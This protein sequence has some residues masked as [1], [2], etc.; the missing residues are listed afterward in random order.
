LVFEVV[1][2]I[3]LYKFTELG[4]FRFSEDRANYHVPV[5]SRLSPPAY[6]FGETSTYFDTKGEF[7]LL[8]SSE[9]VGE[10]L[11]QLFVFFVVGHFFAMFAIFL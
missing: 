3:F 10:G 6:K 11:L 8:I 4:V 2:K 5:W 1:G 7:I 9:V